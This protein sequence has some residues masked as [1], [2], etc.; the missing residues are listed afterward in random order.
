[1]VVKHKTAIDLLSA[2]WVSGKLPPD[3]E[4]YRQV[5][6]WHWPP[7]GGMTTKFIHM[8]REFSGSGKKVAFLSTEDNPDAL[9]RRF[10]M[11]QANNSRIRLFFNGKPLD[12]SQAWEVIIIDHAHVRYKTKDDLCKEMSDWVVAGDARV[13][14]GWVKPR[15]QA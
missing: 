11:L 10:G 3:V 2:A 4:M 15:G 9:E 13:V 8:A 7:S 1:M 14:A 12:R 5:E 6:F